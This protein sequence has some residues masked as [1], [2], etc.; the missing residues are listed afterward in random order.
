M[1]VTCRNIRELR[2]AFLDGDLSPSLMAEVHAHLLQCP[3]CQQQMEMLRAVGDVIARDKAAP[4]LDPEFAGRVV[5]SIPVAIAANRTLSA[6]PRSLTWRLFTRLSVPAAA[7]VLL[8]A[9]AFWPREKDDAV[10]P[11]A[12]AG[13]AAVKQM[14]DPT[15]SAVADTQKTAADLNRLIKLSMDQATQNVREEIA[16]SGHLRR[17][18]EDFS[19]TDVLLQPI[20]DML[21]GPSPAE[22]DN[23]DI[24]RF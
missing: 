21:K 10:R 14:V 20:H 15:L 17:T 7:A 1:A 5:A 16:R 8:M 11:T 3:E 24:V 13:T 6:P 23:P 9:I 18:G 12:V 19:I 4:P 2:D 22:S